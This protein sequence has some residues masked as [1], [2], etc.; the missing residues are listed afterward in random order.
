V[1]STSPE[2]LVARVEQL[3]AQLEP[4]GAAEELAGALMDLYGEGLARIFAAIDEAGA[5]ALRARLVDD[6]VVASLMLIHDLYPVPLEERVQEGLDS[7]RPYMES[8]GGNVELL[9]IVDGV[10]RLRLEGSCHGCAASAS[11]LELAVEE[12]LRATAPDLEGIDVE[13]VVEP[14]LGAFELPMVGSGSGGWQVLDVDVAPG[15]L[16]VAGGLVIA[17]VDGALL[18]YRDRCA[19]CGGAIH[20]GP[21][22]GGTLRCPSCGLDFD[23]PHAGRSAEGPQLSPVPLLRD[24]STIRVAA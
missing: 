11:T 17:N 1:L 10:A 24:G 23:L 16:G 7:V 6:G 9:G 4:G 3:T 13:G 19:R 14:P 2:A 21:L 8:H 22:E 18:A 15:A 20:A 12:A 5:E